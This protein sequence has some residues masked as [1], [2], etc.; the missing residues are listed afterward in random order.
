MDVISFCEARE[1]LGEVLDR[2]IA[3]RAPVV[4]SRRNAEA[5]VLVSLS[6]WYAIEDSMHLQSTDANRSRLMGAIRQLDISH[7][8]P[9]P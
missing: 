1:R 7:R 4:V 9:Q 2:V 3:D 8:L 5:V 6:D